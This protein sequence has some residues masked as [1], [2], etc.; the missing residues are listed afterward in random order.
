MNKSSNITGNSKLRMD[1][2]L[3][4]R[5]DMFAIL[6]LNDEASPAYE[7]FAPLHSLQRMGCQPNATHYDTVYVAPL[8][9]FQNVFEMLEQLFAR[10]NLDRPEDFYGHSLSVSDVVGIHKDGI[11]SFYYVDRVGFKK[12]DGFMEDTETNHTPES[13][14]TT[15]GYIW[16]VITSAIAKTQEEGRNRGDILY[17]GDMLLCRKKEQASGIADLFE[18]MGFNDIHTGYYDPED[19]KRN[20]EVDEYTGWYYVGID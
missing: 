17:D 10:F 3:K 14:T 15:V 7:H 9:P 11:I 20:S 2:F 1:T 16:T 4:S 6:Q 13:S 19:D 18:H 12:L 8:K 5:E